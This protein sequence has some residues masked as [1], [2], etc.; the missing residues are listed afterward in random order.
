MAT[1]PYPPGGSQPRSTPSNP[2][3]DTATRDSLSENLLSQSAEDVEG[4]DTFSVAEEINFDQQSGKVRRVGQA[5]EEVATPG[6][7]GTTAPDAMAESLR[8]PTGR[9]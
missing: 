4:D 3:A 2:T 9:G 5:P 7:T 8:K 6:Q 1:T